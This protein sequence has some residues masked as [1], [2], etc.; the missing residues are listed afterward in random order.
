MNNAVQSRRPLALLLALVLVAGALAL[1]PGLADPASAAPTASKCAKSGRWLAQYYK[2]T[3]FKGK[4]VATR[5]EKRIAASYPARRKPF[6]V[7]WTTTK[8]MKGAYE[9]R[10]RA[11]GKA[12]LRIDGRTVATSKKGR[13]AAGKRTLRR[14]KHTFEV[15]Y[16]KRSGAGSVRAEYV[17]APDRKAPAAP[18][19]VRAVAGDRAVALSW[20]ASSSLDLRGYRILRNGRFVREVTTP[21]FTDTRLTNG[22]TYAYTV[23]A[24]DHRGNASRR[25]TTVR[26]TPR[27]KVAPKAPAGLTAVAG[28]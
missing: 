13:Y 14:G 27:D 5:C 7:R 4:P 11:T 25:S 28:D 15:R 23:V 3:A 2:G 21:R 16:V 26:A 18:T 24:V 10:A 1:V 12:V 17:K 6:S 8:K 19:G 22:T 20:K 9:L